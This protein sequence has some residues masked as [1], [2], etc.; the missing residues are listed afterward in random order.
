MLL[1]NH[2]LFSIS[3]D[4]LFTTVVNRIFQTQGIVQVVTSNF[5][6]HDRHMTLILSSLICNQVSL[7]S[8]ICNHVY[9][10][11]LICNHVYLSSLICNHAYLSRV[12]W[13]AVS[14][15]NSAAPRVPQA[16][17]YLALFRQPKG[18]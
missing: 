4:L 14:K 3:I 8:L 11:S 17:P 6:C 10:S 1:K 2:F 9:L 12:Y 15:Q 16:M 5:F 13:R 7:S 18:P